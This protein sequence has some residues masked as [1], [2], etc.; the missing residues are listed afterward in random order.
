LT[1]LARACCLIAALNGHGKGSDDLLDGARRLAAT[2]TNFLN[3]VQ[4]EKF[5]VT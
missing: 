5:E 2:T 3:S 1:E 4:P